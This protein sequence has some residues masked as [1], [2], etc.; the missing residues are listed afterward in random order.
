MEAI[1]RSLCKQY[2]I[3]RLIATSSLTHSKSIIMFVSNRYKHRRHWFD[4]NSIIY[5]T[6]KSVIFE[7]KK[8]KCF[9][10]WCT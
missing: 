1:S 4:G 7:I 2:P 9:S 6:I 5:H 8:T 10:G 3:Y